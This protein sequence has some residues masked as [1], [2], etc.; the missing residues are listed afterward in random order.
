M[1]LNDINISYTRSGGESNMV[2]EGAFELYLHEEKMIRNNKIDCL[3]DYYTVQLNGVN[4]FFYNISGKEA[5]ADFIETEELNRENV[6]KLLL[7]IQMAYEELGKYLIDTGH[8]MLSPNTVF[9][10]RKS[11]GF[12]V[13]LCYFPSK[14]AGSVSEQLL[15]IFELIL[16]H[17]NHEDEEFSKL[18]YELYDRVA[19][20]DSD[21]MN[22]IELIGKDEEFAAVPVAEEVELE[23]L[24]EDFEQCQEVP[25]KKSGFSLYS[26]DDEEELWDK[27]CDFF[28]GLFKK[29]ETPEIFKRSEDFVVEP[30]EEICEPTVMLNRAS[31]KCVGKL[32]YDGN[33]K[34]DEDDFMIGKDV[35]HI[36]KEDSGNDATLR[37]KAVS[38]HHAKITREGDKFFIEDLNS[39]NGTYLNGRLLSY[40][41]KR[42]LNMLDSILFADVAYVFM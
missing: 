40:K 23:E 24:E 10:N 20:G 11:R 28:A 3:L 6:K 36:G 30:D 31:M 21:L 42:Q 13:K 15:S 27:I 17:V 34:Q 4:R 12:G 22:L 14:E 9:L 41:E 19:K 38:R 18:A 32:I 37:S 8:I 7:Y 35:F 16:Q 33:C 2:L 25:E 39:S 5:L 26:D 29:K 1:A